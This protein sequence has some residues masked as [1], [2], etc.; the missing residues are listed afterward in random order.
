MVQW[1]P[2]HLLVLAC[3]K[4]ASRAKGL[5]VKAASSL[6]DLTSSYAVYTKCGSSRK[7]KHYYSKAQESTACLM[8]A[9]LCKLSLDSNLSK[10]LMLPLFLR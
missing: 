6:I 3:V 7:C 10:K 9:R 2:L 5:P 1:K 4:V 8:M